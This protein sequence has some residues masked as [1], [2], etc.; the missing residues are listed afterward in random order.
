M[1]ALKTKTLAWHHLPKP[2]AAELLRLERRLGLHPAVV[3]ELM[4]STTRSK[5]ETYGQYL[6]I[7][8][9]F[10]PFD[11]Q[12]RKTHPAEVDFIL[13]KD[14][15]ISITYEPIGPLDDFFKKCS[16]EKSCEDLYASK[17]PGHLLFHVLK[18]LYS[19]SL[20]EL[21]HI[22]EN[23]DRIEEEIFAGRE[24]E[25]VEELSVVRRDIIDFRRAVKPQF[26]TL[27][28]LTREGALF[29]GPSLRPF[30]TSLA[31]EFT[32]VWDLLENNK[33]ALD[34]L[35]DNNATL[36]EVKQNDAMRIL[37]IMA[38]TTFPLMLFTALFSMDT[39]S[40]PIVG[41]R[42]DFWIILAIMI[43]ATAGMFTFIK[44][45]KWL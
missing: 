39:V 8:L 42:Y 15:L 31:G 33:E 1:P 22:Q 32:K 13:T 44:R 16:S 25:V 20:R 41:S 4:R 29:F 24:R 5:V 34:A 9:H 35:Y 45:K 14:E 38:F 40:T 10:P 17:T 12:E 2:P 19:F 36:L 7:I 27:E 21:D 28:S 37:T 11:P 30:F 26:I 6:Y 43:L 18:E 23:I 3:E